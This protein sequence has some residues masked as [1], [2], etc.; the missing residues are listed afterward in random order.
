MAT[1][2]ATAGIST[3]RPL[4]NMELMS[5]IRTAVSLKGLHSVV[6]LSRRNIEPRHAFA[7]LLLMP[8]LLSLSGAAASQAGGSARTV[9][10]SASPPPPPPALQHQLLQ[11]LA[12]VVSPQLA[13]TETSRLVKLLWAV[14]KVDPM[15]P[16]VDGIMSELKR[17]D[18][19]KVKQSNSVDVAQLLYCLGRLERDPDDPLVSA[20]FAAAVPLLPSCNP[21]S[22]SHIAWA[23]SALKHSKPQTL[24]PLAQACNAKLYSFEPFSISML[25]NSLACVHHYDRPLF[26]NGVNLYL[27]KVAAGGMNNVRLASLLWACARVRH[28]DTAAYNA[29]CAMVLRNWETADARALEDTF[30]GLGQL[31]HYNARLFGEAAPKLCEAAG[32]MSANMI[33]TIAWAYARMGH[34]DPKLLRALCRAL[35]KH[36]PE[37]AT[38]NVISNVLW[39]LVV[40]QH[41]DLPTLS[42][43][44]QHAA[45]AFQQQPRFFVEG[46]HAHRI[47]VSLVELQDLK[48]AVPWDEA[49]FEA[50]RGH[51]GPGGPR[52]V[53]TRSTLQNTVTLRLSQ[54]GLTPKAEAVDP[55]GLFTVD[56]CFRAG[57]DLVAV[58]V[59]GPY[60]FMT[61]PQARLNAATQ[62]RNRQL[63]R[64]FGKVIVVHYGRFEESGGDSMQGQLSYLRG[65]LAQH[66]VQ[67][68]EQYAAEGAAA[69]ASTAASLEGATAASSATAA[70]ES[71]ARG[72]AAAP[73][74]A[75]APRLPVPRP[76]AAVSK[77]RSRGDEQVKDMASKAWDTLL[78]DTATEQVRPQRVKREKM[79][80]RLRR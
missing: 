76:A 74:A 6:T 79:T 59:D 34:H 25:L 23:C 68:F 32:G 10:G 78:K 60:H 3:A 77:A 13:V 42:W 72:G 44:M 15:H 29:A 2:P 48:L 16:L 69:A 49:M 39:A 71:L 52:I 26:T 64:R 75:A 18:F 36:P 65:L 37:A 28:M 61:H 66:G 54:L 8:K 35:L 57:N 14:V 51:H 11:Q 58:E 38:P 17:T 53:A 33:S 80:S 1:S 62:L 7:A 21:H 50:L 24:G 63:A 4:T 67:G 73:A 22:L 47:F 55:T 45:R 20:A 41:H 27:E 43:L 70:A 56:I 30:W 19:W 31:E 12:P 46:G 9:G 40:L 5:S